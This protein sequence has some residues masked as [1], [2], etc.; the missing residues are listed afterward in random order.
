[1]NERIRMLPEFNFLNAKP[2]LPMFSTQ[3]FNPAINNLTAAQRAELPS[4]TSHLRTPLSSTQEAQPAS[5][6]TFDNFFD[7]NP[8]WLRP[9]NI[10]EYRG[11]LYGKVA[12]N[13][14]GVAAAQKSGTSPNSNGNL[15]LPTGFK[16]AFFSTPRSSSSGPFLASSGKESR[17]T[18]PYTNDLLAFQSPSRAATTEEQQRLKTTAFVA[19][20]ATQTLFS[21][22][23]GAFV[24]AFAGNTAG[25]LMSREKVAAVLSGRASLKVVPNDDLVGMMGG[26]EI[27]STPVTRPTTPS[28]CAF[29]DV[30]QRWSSGKAGERPGTPTR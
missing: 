7:T 20:L 21:R 24:E 26:L 27:S 29:D 15:P 16:P 2:T 6:G 10:E 18:Y 19:G 13:M 3:S 17:D 22:M 1:M 28:H 14:A 9:E 5:R 25:G 8:L 30:M 4:L 23:T 12:H 11:Q